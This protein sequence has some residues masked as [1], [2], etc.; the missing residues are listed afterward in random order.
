MS[1]PAQFAVPTAFEY[2]A[3]LLWATSG[4]IVGWRKGYY[5]APAGREDAIRFWWIRLAVCTRAST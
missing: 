1:P 5:Q 4:A 3:V 2:I